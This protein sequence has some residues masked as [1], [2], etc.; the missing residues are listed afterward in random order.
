MTLPIAVGEG[1]APPAKCN[2][3]FNKTD[4]Q[5]SP[6]RREF[7]FMAT[8]NAIGN[9]TFCGRS[10]PLPYGNLTFITSPNIE[11]KLNVTARIFISVGVGAIDDP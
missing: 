4:D 8:P 9:S 6:L 5:W 10:K 2:H 1:L 11:F 3:K 7:N